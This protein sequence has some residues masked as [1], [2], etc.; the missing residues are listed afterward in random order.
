MDMD[1]DMSQCDLG[2]GNSDAGAGSRYSDTDDEG[3]AHTRESILIMYT[4]QLTNAGLLGLHGA[5]LLPPRLV[6]EHD[7]DS[8]PTITT[9]AVP[10]LNVNFKTGVGKLDF[11]NWHQV[12]FCS[13]ANGQYPHFCDCDSQGA[14]ALKAANMERALAFSGADKV[15]EGDCIHI[16]LLKSLVSSDQSDVFETCTLRSS[17]SMSDEE[18]S[19]TPCFELGTYQCREKDMVL[20]QVRPNLQTP[21]STTPTLHP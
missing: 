2:G 6:H 13:L 11:N 20:H 16:H 10:D 15:L 14:R 3:V 18:D 9:F 12:G 21:Y 19:G 4:T 17:P 5:F 8:T 1:I 7:G